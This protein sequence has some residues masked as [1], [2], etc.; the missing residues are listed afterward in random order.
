L[1]LRVFDSRLPYLSR[2]QISSSS[3]TLRRHLSVLA[4]MLAASQ[5][6]TRCRPSAKSKSSLPSISTLQHFRFLRPFFS[7]LSKRPTC[8]ALHPGSAALRVWLPFRRF[9]AL[10]VLGSLFQLP[11]LL[12]FSL[13]SFLPT[14][15]RTSC[16]QDFFRSGTFL[17]NLPACYRCFNGFIPPG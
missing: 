15:D 5:F 12:G 7:L 8:V 17:T 11:T 3:L 16:F 2:D 14:G 6:L 1:D 10:K 13:R 4:L 9:Q